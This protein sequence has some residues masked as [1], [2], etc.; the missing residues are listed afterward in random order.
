[1]KK[2]KILRALSVGLSKFIFI[3]F[4]KFFRGTPFQK[5][6]FF[7]LFYRGF[8][9][10]LVGSQDDIPL[11]IEHGG[12]SFH[13]PPR[14]NSMVPSLKCGTYEVAEI[15]FVNEYLKEGMTF[16]DVGANFGLYTVIAASRVGQSGHVFSFEPSKMALA[17]LHRNTGGLTNVEVVPYGVGARPGSHLLYVPPENLG[18]SSFTRKLGR[19]E[20]VGTLD[21]DSFFLESR[22][23]RK[24]DLVKID[25]EGFELE[26]LAGMDKLLRQK[27]VVLLEFIPD[28]FASNGQDPK[29]L[30]ESLKMRFGEIRFFREPEGG[31]QKL[32]SYSQLDKQGGGNIVLNFGP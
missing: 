11:I 8:S 3:L 9:K 27:P 22:A 32:D 13:V 26:V 5:S 19:P 24:I 15:A 17:Y 18:C 16:V 14:D 20:P 10:F 21:L 29:T 30:Y 28:F 7:Q 2:E 25:V 12:F 4:R 6:R 31:L 23:P 1:M